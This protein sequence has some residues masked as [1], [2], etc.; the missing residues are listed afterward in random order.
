MEEAV[1]PDL[2]CSS[3][4]IR[5]ISSQ[6][7]ADKPR[8][9]KNIR[10]DANFAKGVTVVAMWLLCRHRMTWIRTANTHGNAVKIPNERMRSVLI[11]GEEIKSD[12][13][14]G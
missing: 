12:Q 1:G 13:L 5:V 10:Q 4:R 3:D 9:D 2:D 7:S 11:F 14:R 6:N 8:I